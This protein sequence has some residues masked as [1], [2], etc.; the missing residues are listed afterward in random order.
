MST[1]SLRFQNILERVTDGE[2]A[3]VKDN[4]EYVCIDKNKAKLI[5]TLRGDYHI[6]NEQ[7]VKE[8]LGSL[9][10]IE[11]GDFVNQPR[12]ARLLLPVVQLFGLFF[13]QRSWGMDLAYVSFLFILSIFKLEVLS[14]PVV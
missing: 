8:A 7:A 11:A 4:T 10:F 14:M 5:I 9:E 1:R 3:Y 2:Q 6:A 13:G 12:L